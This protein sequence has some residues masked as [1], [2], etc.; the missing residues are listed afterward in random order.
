MNVLFFFTQN[1]HAQS[2]IML[3]LELLDGGGDMEQ[4]QARQYGKTATKPSRQW[5]ENEKTKEEPVSK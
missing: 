4:S 3:L 1:E 5:M 2:D